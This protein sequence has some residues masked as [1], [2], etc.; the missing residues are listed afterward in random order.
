M[1]Q[2]LLSLLF[3]L[4]RT[5]YSRYA[6]TI[7]PC[8]SFQKTIDSGKCSFLHGVCLCGHETT[9]TNGDH[10][11]VDNCQ[12]GMKLSTRSTA[13]TRIS[14]LLLLWKINNSW[15]NLAKKQLH[16]KHKVQHNV[17][18]D[19]YFS[20]S[21]RHFTWSLGWSTYWY[22]GQL[23]HHSFRNYMWIAC[24]GRYKLICDREFM[25]IT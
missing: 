7:Q 18:D 10:C 16:V 6:I 13:I 14:T 17:F 15:S 3:R 9:N 23:L 24:F 12:V 22:Q 5:Q 19:H 8:L 2:L 21:C 11:R 1:V 20:S 25:S 4:P